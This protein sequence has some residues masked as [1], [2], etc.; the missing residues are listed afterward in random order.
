MKL[1]FVLSFCQLLAL[2]Q[3]KGIWL[4]PK[5]FQK[6]SLTIYLIIESPKLLSLPQINTVSEGVSFRLFCS[7]QFGSK[8]LFFQWMKNGQI[9]NTS[10]QTNYKIENSDEHSLFL[11]KSV[12]RSDSGNY[13]C[14]V[15]NA[16]G[17]DSQSALLIVKGLAIKYF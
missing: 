9:L 14:N 11:I 12:V 5:I 8:P 13:S 16:F 17:S 15:R 1:I 7:V 6:H 10:P 4:L 2:I 3:C